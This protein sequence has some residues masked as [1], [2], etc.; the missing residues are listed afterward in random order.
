MAF[1]PERYASSPARGLDVSWRVSFGSGVL[2][3]WILANDDECPDV[4]TMLAQL[5]E[6]GPSTVFAEFEHAAEWARMAQRGLFAFDWVV[7]DGPYRLIAAPASPLTVDEL[8]PP[9]R[10]ITRRSCLRHLCFA[11]LREVTA[12]DVERAVRL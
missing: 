4:E 5:A 12:E 7:H 1:G 2:P 10:A 6:R 3:A 8:P 11:S 9:L